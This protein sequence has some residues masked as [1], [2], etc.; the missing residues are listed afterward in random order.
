MFAGKTFQYTYS[1][2]C[3]ATESVAKLTVLKYS[4]DKTRLSGPMMYIIE[5]HEFMNVTMMIM[6]SY[7]CTLWV[8][9]KRS[10]ALV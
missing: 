8:L 1:Y 3:V 4:L 2:V 5:Y 7:A 10:H 9:T 6:R